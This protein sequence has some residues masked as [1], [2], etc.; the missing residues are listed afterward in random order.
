VY[1]DFDYLCDVFSGIATIGST[2]GFGVVSEA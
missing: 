1:G 2:R